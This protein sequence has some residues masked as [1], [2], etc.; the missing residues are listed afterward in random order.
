[1]HVTSYFKEDVAYQEN[2]LTVGQ[3][4]LGHEV[5]VVTS[6]VEYCFNI[7]KDNRT[8]PLGVTDYKG[9]KIHRIPI[10]HEIK[11]RFVFYRDLMGKLE[12]LKPD[13]I[14][15]YDHSPALFTCVRYKKKYHCKLYVTVHSTLSN[16]MN[17]RF[18][19][20][21]HKVLWRSIIHFIQKYYDK[22]LCGAPECRQFAEEIYHI[23]SDIIHLVSLPGDTSLMADYDLMRKQARDNLG[24]EDNET[25]IFHTGKLPTNKKT[26]EVM[27]AVVELNNPKVMLF[28]V[29]DVTEE[30][31]PVMEEYC[32]KYPAIQ[33]LGWKKP[34]EMKR[35]L[36]GADL[37]LQP[38][39]LSNT[40]IE[41]IC[42]GVPLLLLD[43]PQGR[44]LT[45]YGNGELLSEAT[46]E[47]ITAG[48]RKVIEP[49]YHKQLK[50]KTMKA[51]QHFHYKEIARQTLE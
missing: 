35:L 39:S 2:Y 3:V 44:F 17:S 25:A 42:C 14:F 50:E 23:K 43:T 22:V 18:G 34:D 1:M 49:E 48:I 13:I 40:F 37:L 10:T 21:Y 15:F 51:S 46:V 5:A 47:C 16:S 29:G 45:Q 28:I 24:I 31:F 38:G 6:N 27:E 36:M 30:F 32:R 11:N 9:V 19:K 8:H 12:E 26:L 33:Y 7:N 20:P 41:A 4:E